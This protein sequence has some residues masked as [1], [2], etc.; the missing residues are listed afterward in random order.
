MNTLIP[1]NQLI[2]ISSCPSK[3]NNEWKK[4]SLI[5]TMDSGKKKRTFSDI[6]FNLNFTVA[7][8]GLIVVIN[9]I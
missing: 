6:F 2:I 8:L 1:L 7:E 4:K 5:I 9:N 3:Q